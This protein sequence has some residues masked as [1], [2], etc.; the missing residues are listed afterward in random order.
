MP[1]LRNWNH[2]GAFFLIAGRRVREK[3]KKSNFVSTDT[4]CPLH[5]YD[6]I[7]HGEC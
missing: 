3:E 7:Y 2:V 6:G 1:P 4:N 5:Y